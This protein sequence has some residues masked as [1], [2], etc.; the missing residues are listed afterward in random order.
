MRDWNT[1]NAT[2][3]DK[4]FE[5][6]DRHR[7]DKTD[8]ADGEAQAVAG[9]EEGCSVLAQVVTIADGRW[10]LH[11]E[12]DDGVRVRVFGGPVELGGRLRRIPSNL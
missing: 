5:P 7:R 8:T 3:Y 9:E 6:A 2:H 1:P 4:D 11:R 12:S 10:L